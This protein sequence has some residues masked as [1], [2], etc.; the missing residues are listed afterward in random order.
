MF[1]V[2]KMFLFKYVLKLQQALV[3]NIILEIIFLLPAFL[4]SDPV[5]LTC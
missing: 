2:L 1:P 3:S 4:E 5:F